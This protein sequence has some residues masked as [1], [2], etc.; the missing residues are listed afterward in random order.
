MIPALVIE[1]NNHVQREF[2]FNCMTLQNRQSG[3]TK[4]TLYLLI[5][6]V[7]TGCMTNDMIAGG[8]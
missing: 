1:I 6:R 5:S 4:C 8:S 2:C 7:K 3:N